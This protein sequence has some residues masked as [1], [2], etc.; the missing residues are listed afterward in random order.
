MY[1]G[2]NRSYF[3]QKFEQNGVK[4]TWSPGG[5]AAPI[6]PCGPVDPFN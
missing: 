4:N 6:D 2:A 5:P 1:S 3:Q